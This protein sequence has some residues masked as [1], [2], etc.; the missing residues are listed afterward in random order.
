MASSCITKI[1]NIHPASEITWP[2][3]SKIQ[4]K[5]HVPFQ[6]KL[7]GHDDIL[8]CDEIVR[9]VPGKRLVAFGLWGDKNIVAKIF[10]E[11]G[12]ARRHAKREVTGI[13][14]LIASNTP[15]PTLLLNTTAQKQKIHILIFERII[16]AVNLDALLQQKHFTPELISI[17]QEIT[18]ELA[19]Q[20]VLG[21]VQ[22]D[23][24]LK[25]FL[26]TP[27][28]IYTL[29]G[30]SIIQHEGILSKEKSLDHLALFFSQMGA[31]NESLLDTL[32]Q[33]YSQSRSWI[34]KKSDIDFLKNST[35]KYLHDR[36]VRYEK[37]I[38][39]S[40][41]AFARIQTGKS[42][43]M[44][45]RAYLSFQLEEI[46][47]N[48]ESIFKQH[49][50][51]LIKEGRS[52]TVIKIKIDSKYFILKRY[53][54]KSKWHALRRCLRPS[55]A[56]TSWTLA[57]R[58]HLM[59]IPTA[60]PIAF[61]ENRFLGFRGKSYFIME[62]I[63]GPTAKDF[64]ESQSINPNTVEIAKKIIS[65]FLNLAKVCLT[66]G[67]LKATNILIQDNDFPVI[68][69]LDGMQEHSSRLKLKKAFKQEIARFMKNWKMLPD[70]YH[71]F[72]KI[73]AKIQK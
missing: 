42:L 58:L 19:T 27:K 73:T 60:K 31:G 9:L 54:L 33:T 39:R 49:E 70:I 52:S 72:E 8:F 38:Q 5:N 34:I 63:D 66:H 11:R 65:I 26:I 61:I 51:A 50:T 1:N 25:N 55:R 15:T 47:L 16:D 62:F 57:Q 43:V 29:D 18:L 4:N 35:A 37:K 20:H 28:K 71:M 48:P 67:D 10:Y 6:L 36:W 64:F 30:G 46:L 24:H 17:M 12:N 21:I 53:N 7:S 13:E 22:K 2:E 41:S 32:F 44:Y 14:K 3:L 45:D 40:S 59:N 68:I 23:L 69:D 56:A